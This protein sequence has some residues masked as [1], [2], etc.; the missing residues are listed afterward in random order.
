MYRAECVDL[1][2]DG[3]ILEVEEDAYEDGI[4]PDRH[5]D[6]RYLEEMGLEI[7]LLLKPPYGKQ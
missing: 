3:F 1:T 7:H 4:V 2:D 6:S 5:I